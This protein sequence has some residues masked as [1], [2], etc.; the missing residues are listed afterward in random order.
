MKVSDNL[1]KQK[2]EEEVNIEIKWKEIDEN[3]YVRSCK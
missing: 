3:L 2:P 1:K